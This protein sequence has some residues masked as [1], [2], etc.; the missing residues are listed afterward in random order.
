MIT[1]IVDAVRR[2]S[3]PHQHIAYFATLLS[4]VLATDLAAA[5]Q[6]AAPGSIIGR[7]TDETGAVLPGVTITVTS[8][9]LQAPEVVVVTNEAGEYRITPL[10]IGRYS[11]E[12]AISGF[13]T[14]RQE[15]VQLSLGFVAKLDQVMKVATVS[16]TV[17]VSGA[18][19]LVDV[20]STTVRTELTNEEVALIPTS[21]DGIKAFFSQTP[22]VRSNLDVGSSGLTDSVQMRVYGQPG[23]AWDMLEGVMMA[24]AGAGAASGTHIDFGSVEGV[25]IET[26]GNNAEMPRR[27]ILF[28]AVMKSGGNDFHGNAVVYGSTGRLES[29]N[30]D[31]DLLAQGVRGSAKL[32]NL[33]DV[34][35]GLGGRI[36]RDKLWFYAAYHNQGFDRDVLDAFYSDGSPVVLN[37][38]L[39]YNMQKVSYQATRGNKISAFHHRSH[40]FQR[41]G[42]SRFQLAESRENVNIP[43]TV[44]KVDWQA[45]R[46][47]ALVT[48]LQYGV[49]EHPRYYDGQDPGIT[50]VATTDIATQVVTGAALSDGNRPYDY[51]HHAKGVVSYYRTDLFAGNHEFKLGFDHLAGGWS[52]ARNSRAFN[53]QLVFNNGAPFQINTYNYPIE[54]QNETKYLGV[55]SQDAWTI[56][57]RLTLNL[58]I[59][60]AHDNGYVPA[61]CREAAEFAAAACYPKIQMKIWNTVA[62][63]LHLAY[64]VRGNG[65]TAIK[66]GWGRFDHMRELDPE[67]A[68][69][70]RNNATTTLWDWRDLNG[71]RA[72]DPGEVN[73]DPNGPDFR[74]ISG[75]TDAV[76]NPN[77]KQ[78]KADEFSLTIEQQ[79]LANWAVRVTGIYSRN[80]NQYRLAE[81]Q[82]PYEA[83]NIPITNADPGPDG[84]AGTADD[85]GTFVTYYDYP[86][87]LSGR[88]FAGTMLVNDPR[89]DATYKTI[90]VASVK[91]LSQGWQFSTA[92]TATKQNVPF[93]QYLP[94]NPNVE[95]NSANRTWE[96][97]TKASGAY[98][99]PYSIIGSANFELRSGAAQARQVLFTG[100]RQIRSIVV[101]VEPLGSLRLPSTKLLDFRAGKRFALGTGRSLELRVDFFNALNFNTV[102]ARV[103]RSGSTF[104]LP[105]QLGGSLQSIQLPRILQVG[106]SYEF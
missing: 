80:F 32:H 25:R 69:N 18:S 28:D 43:S 98:T 57:R 24:R 77:E 33:W 106:L 7:V 3:G 94:F 11:V 55:Y 20:V 103:L 64:D 16:E 92:F 58:G 35:A 53:Y 27:G 78:P 37:T 9:A 71:N 95:I 60:Y 19:P 97:T 23:E 2:Q 85:P 1:R 56:A 42:A 49:W 76:P 26:V 72:Y 15:N 100:G 93:A 46:G 14:L 40:D 99:F 50:K 61:Q 41:R 62:P 44:G 30:V 8:P 22:G 36:V 101:N 102:T 63:R 10:P 6:G 67:V 79:L 51:R 73:L 29:N 31:A 59:R 89:A 17:V 82:R 47:N 86:A 104:L 48:S 96:W 75:T 105:S 88:Q 74:S 91:R 21:R 65:R 34:S 4:F 83:Y 39:T 13:S 12:Y 84:R 38:K 52:A 54:P 45:V 66:G 87:S 5:G 90:E 70:N 81:T 68:G